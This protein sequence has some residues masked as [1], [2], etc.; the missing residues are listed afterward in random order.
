[1]KIASENLLTNSTF[2]WPI[3]TSLFNQDDLRFI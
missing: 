1:M 3:I 2:F